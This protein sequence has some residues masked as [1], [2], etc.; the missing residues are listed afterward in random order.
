MSAATSNAAPFSLK[1][2]L[3]SFLLLELEGTFF[4]NQ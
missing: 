3:S 2:F 4:S 1:E